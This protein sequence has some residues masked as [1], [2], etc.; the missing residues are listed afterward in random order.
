MTMRMVF[1][2]AIAA[3]GFATVAWAHAHLHASQPPV[4]GTVS[5]APTEVVLTFSEALEPALSSVAVLDAA[6]AHVEQG[7]LHVAD[8]SGKVVAISLKPLGK[9]TYTVEWH[10]TSVDTHRTEGTFRFIV[11]P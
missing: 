7:A 10:A 11:A 9:G 5:K 8:A 4:G 3:C 6:G 2:A 1:L